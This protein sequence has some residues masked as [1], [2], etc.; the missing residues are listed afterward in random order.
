MNRSMSLRSQL[1]LLFTALALGATAVLGSLAYR[2]SRE[3]LT[4]NALRAVQ[5]TAQERTESLRRRLQARN[6]RAQA[7]LIAAAVCGGPARSVGAD[8]S[9]CTRLLDVFRATEGFSAA[10]LTRPGEPP[11]TVGPNAAAL[12]REPAFPM[13]QLA[14][15]G[16]HEPGHPY[17]VIRA[18]SPQSG[19]SLTL[20]FDE[21]E[22]V[23]EI[24]EDQAG[25]GESGETFLAD[26]R[27]F[28]ITAPRYP[29]HSGESHPIAAAPMRRCLSGEGGAM[30]A[31]DYVPTEVIHGFRPVGFIGGGCVMAHIHQAEAFAPAQ[32]LGRRILASGLLLSVLSVLASIALARRVTR[33]ISRLSHAARALEKG[34]F[35]H[36]IPH[37]GPFEI[38]TFAAAFAAMVKGLRDRADRLDAARGRAEEQA[39]ELEVLNEELQ[40]Q[41]SQLEEAQA[42][43]EMSND[44]LHRANQ[45]LAGA[46][47]RM[48]F[49]MD[50]M[51]Q[52]VWTA[53]ASGSVNF[54]NQRWLEYAGLSF[55]ELRDWGWRQIIH[56]DDWEENLRVWQHSIDSGNDFELEHRFLRAD[57]VY[58]WHLSRG[59]ARRDGQGNIQ[60]WVGTN[61]DIHEQKQVEEVLRESAEQLRVTAAAAHTERERLE[62]IFT[63]APAVMA[64]YTGPEHIITLV[65]PTWEKTVGKTNAIGKPFREVFPEFADSG[66]FE[67]LDQV[68]QTGEPYVDPEVTVPM[69]RWGSGTLEETSWHLVWLPL[70]E[71]EGQSEREIL[72]HAVEVTEQVRARREIDAARAAAEEANHAK[73]GFL[74]TM[75][76]ELRT[77]LNAMIGYTDLLQMGVPEAVGRQAG[78]QVRRIGLSARHLLQLIEEILTYSRLEAGREEVQVEQVDLGELVREVSAIIEPLAQEKGLRFEVHRSEGLSA[79]ETDPRKL[80]QILINLV[81]NAVKFTEEGEVDLAVL[82]EEGWAVFRVRDTGIGIAPEHLE[83][84]FEPFQQVETER[85]RRVHGTG[86]GLSVSR[87]L[88]ELLGGGLTV[89][90][91]PGDGSTFAVRLPVRAPEPARAEP[92]DR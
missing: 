16:F 21:I 23:Q 61:T 38:R 25:L 62:R 68:Y 84:I 85:A 24:F 86:L 2:A 52:K 4:R 78:E 37:E 57:G 33:P 90:S 51:P 1:I 26:S 55:T 67:L 58:R 65:N 34:E 27:G 8:R 30:L 41:A 5:A 47:E 77:P 7:F 28:F 29:G 72:V 87:R 9:E 6:D 36:P 20:R 59:L 48:R 79:I 44:E 66:L 43:L 10:A 60:M 70:P 19:A 69:E 15:F 18:A 81:G 49:L 64:I 56:P 14:R 39:M 22:I 91:T 74:A 3:S 46:T 54:F 89:E 80:R 82:E 17:Y 71:R 32:A 76:H 88:T 13:D 92:T 73:A 40:S 83:A 35:D 12:A 45:E 63:A 53:D 11:I 75:S 42:E 50:A 31:L